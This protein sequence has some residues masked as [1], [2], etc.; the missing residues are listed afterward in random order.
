[1]AKLSFYRLK[2]KYGL[3]YRAFRGFKRLRDDAISGSYLICFRNEGEFS[4]TE[5]IQSA[6]VWYARAFRTLFLMHP[7]SIVN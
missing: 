2:Y 3:Y 5:G 6:A 4:S 1:M 7:D